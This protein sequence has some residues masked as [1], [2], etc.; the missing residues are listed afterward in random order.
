MAP[1]SGEDLAAWCRCGCWL[2]SPRSSAAYARDAEALAP[3][4]RPLTA[5][6]QVGTPSNGSTTAP[7]PA[8]ATP[9]ADAGVR[10]PPSALPIRGAPLHDGFSP[11]NVSATTSPTAIRCL[12]RRGPCRRAAADSVT[13]AMVY[14][15]RTRL[16]NGLVAVTASRHFWMP[17]GSAAPRPRHAEISYTFAPLLRVY[18]QCSVVML[19][20]PIAR[21]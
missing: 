2:A 1:G 15:P 10:S 6:R 19:P 20:L 16:T 3:A 18:T 21:C 14:R 12:R 17:N 7:S 9:C 11:P 4:S 8:A 5:C 13:P